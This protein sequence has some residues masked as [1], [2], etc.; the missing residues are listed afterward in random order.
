MMSA[1]CLPAGPA[2]TS[3]LPVIDSFGTSPGS[4]TSDEPSTLSWSVSNATTVNIDQGIGNVPLAGSRVV[5]PNTTTNYT[6]VAT[7]ESGSMTATA[8]VVVAEETATLPIIDSFAAAPESITL[9]KSSALSWNVSDA[10]EV[11]IDPAV[12][13]VEPMGSASVSPEAST[14]YTLTA[15]NESGTVTATAQVVV[16]APSPQTITLFSVGAEDGSVIGGGVIHPHPYAGD[17]DKNRARQA[18]L[19]FDISEIATGAIVESASLDLS[20]GDELGEPFVGLGVMKVYSLQYG[21]LD[22]SEFVSG[23]PGGEMYK[24]YSR[25]RGAF[26]SSKLTSEIQARVDAGAP[27][28]QVRLQFQK[29]TNGDYRDDMLRVRQ[30]E[31]VIT[32]VN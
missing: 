17:T 2:P 8:R 25:P 22:G 6:L 16:T 13:S 29:H 32:Y 9:G 19:S 11:T 31:L 4:I 24:Y 23:F 26:R 7:N 14:T 30:P 28:F 5:S 12:G 10:A 15:T 18:F 20:G 3:Q 21:T 1:G 27:R